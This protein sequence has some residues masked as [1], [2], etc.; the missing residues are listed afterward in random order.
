MWAGVS[1]PFLDNT[2]SPS[3]APSQSQTQS[4]PSTSQWYHDQIVR[5]LPFMSAASRSRSGSPSRNRSNTG[6]HSPKHL[7]VL[8][9]R[10]RSDTG[11]SSN[12]S[13][14]PSMTSSA[15][16]SSKRSSYDGSKGA[17]DFV[18]PLEKEESLSKSFFS[19]GNR[20]LR[21]QG[22]KFNLSDTLILDEEEEMSSDQVWY[23]E[24]KTKRDKPAVLRRINRQRDSISHAQLKSRISEPFHFQHITHTS[25]GQ[26][27]P[28]EHTHPH[29]LATEFSI[30][31][32]SQRPNSELKGIHAQNLS[33]RPYT[34]EEEADWSLDTLAPDA[35]SLFTRSPPGSPQVATPSSPEAR[36]LR[37]SPHSVENFSRPVSR[38]V[39]RPFSS[40]VVPPP[41]RS[42]RMPA[43]PESVR[44]GID[45]AEELAGLNGLSL[46]PVEDKPVNGA[47]GYAVSP[48][49]PRPVAEPIE[50]IGRA[51]SPSENSTSFTNLSSL[52]Q[53]DGVPEQDETSPL[54]HSHVISFDPTPYNTYLEPE[55]VEAPAEM[56][57]PSLFL[58][59]LEETRFECEDMHSPII[60][61]NQPSK[62]TL[63]AGPK[64]PAEAVGMHASNSSWEADI[65]YCYEHAAES[66]S[67]FD[68][69]RSSSEEHRDHKYL[70]HGKSETSACFKVNS[71]SFYLHPLDTTTSGR[72]TPE[73]QPSSGISTSTRTESDVASPAV[74]N[75]SFGVFPTT[76]DSL[77]KLPRTNEIQVLE[78]HFE[79][80]SHDSVYSH[81]IHEDDEYHVDEP[82][83]IRSG[84]SPLSKCNSQESMM[85]FR[86]ASIVRKHRSSTSTNSVPDLIHSPNCSREMVDREIPTSPLADRP[87]MP[88]PPVSP[89]YSRP[90]PLGREGVPRMPFASVSA[91]EPTSIPSISMHDRSKSASVLE[92]GDCTIVRSNNTARKRSSTLSRG[93]RKNRPSYSLFPVT[94]APSPRVS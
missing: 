35:P 80:V 30:I 70:A 72:T 51:F 52:V 14:V 62:S 83:Y 12:L 75:H 20:I 86:A 44:C 43:S 89:I 40:T 23:G 1:M 78:T 31:R 55:V 87:V 69:H 13:P 74:F 29:D 68:W 25:R 41:R 79:D 9:L 32:A 11:N 37:R 64:S 77:D 94:G 46:S 39:R 45:P 34:A 81:V 7:S 27:P 66:N 38:I 26:L 59:P 50:E 65:D 2:F 85:L 6:T 24:K 53:L 91:I 28:I 10:A 47:V 56:K 16:L 5:E 71:G 3:P 58:S 36:L 22:S 93:V 33:Y 90:L 82:V 8:G 67:N 92:S 57:K 73:L 76:T 54:A 18:L 15:E 88:R 61:S 49:E 60:P 19:R 42:S 84:S 21:R 63:P 17:F 48:M 4:R